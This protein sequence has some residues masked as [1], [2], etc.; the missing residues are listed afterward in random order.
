MIRGS[1]FVMAAVMVATAIIGCGRTK[2]VAGD[3]AV[4]PV[5]RP[6]DITG[7]PDGPGDSNV[8]DAFVEHDAGGGGPCDAGNSGAGATEGAWFYVLPPVADHALR[9]G[10]DLALIQRR[11][12]VLGASADGSVVVGTSEFDLLGPVGELRSVMSGIEIFRWTVATGVVGLGFPASIRPTDPR[13]GVCSVLGI[14][15]DGSVVLG[16]CTGPQGPVAIRWT[17]CSG[18]VVIDAPAGTSRLTPNAMTPD[19][20]VMIGNLKV[21]GLSGPMKAFRWS[22]ETGVEIL[23]L[24]T[25]HDQSSAWTMTADG[26]IVFG[27]AFSPDGDHAAFRWSR[28][29]GSVALPRLPAHIAC[30]ITERGPLVDGDVAAGNCYQGDRIHGYHWTA[31]A[32]TVA[33]GMPAGTVDTEVTE[34]SRDGAV[35]MGWARGP[36]VSSAFRWTA[37]T[38]AVIVSPAGAAR[39]MSDDGAVIAGDFD[40]EGGVRAF[41]WTDGPGTVALPL[42]AGDVQGTV[43]NVSRDGSIVTGTSYR[44]NGASAP[45]DLPVAVYWD[46]A[47]AV[48]SIAGGLR[49]VG[50]DLGGTLLTS[51]TSPDGKVFWGDARTSEGERRAWVGR[52]P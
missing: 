27:T 25:G 48:H 19:A 37:A 51:A 21:G 39:A 20:R 3:G 11:T 34:L 31:A 15:A 18:I 38:G 24:P 32:G 30:G 35:I 41:R 45:A 49:A 7:V 22:A 36:A 40:F 46:R 2:P 10:D 29:I 23:D 50:V 16:T 33:L 17:P 42:L 9:P 1:A 44:I 47:G 26:N 12:S 43:T 28:E 14:S 8:G 4:P 5:D 6:F 13:F 52:A